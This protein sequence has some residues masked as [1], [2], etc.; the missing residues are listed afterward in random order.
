M[1]EGVERLAGLRPLVSSPCFLLPLSL[2]REPKLLFNVYLK[3][4]LRDLGDG[5]ADAPRGLVFKQNFVALDPL[6]APA[7]VALA[8]HW[9]AGLH[10]RQPPRELLEVCAAVEPA[11]QTR[12]GDFQGVG[13]RDEVL[14]IEDGADVRAHFRAVLVGDAAR[15]VDEDADDGRAR[16]TGKFD[17]DEFEAALFSG[18]ARDLAHTRFDGSLP[19]QS[20]SRPPFSNPRSKRKSG[21]EPT[22]RR[23]RAPSKRLII[24][25][26][27]CAWQPGRR[28]AVSGEQ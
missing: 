28:W 4:R 21:R 11:L 9:V 12:R 8:A 14:H 15:L 2:F 6:D 23:H 20:P 3:I 17:V 13:G 18:A 19:V 27:S 22:G 16:A 1:P 26:T 5:D 24:R 25:E 10:L 7:E